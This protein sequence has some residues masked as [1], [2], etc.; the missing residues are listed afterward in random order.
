MKLFQKQLPLKVKHFFLSV[1]LKW[2]IL[3]WFQN[4]SKFWKKY[5]FVRNIHNRI[6]KKYVQLQR[7]FLIFY[8]F[9]YI[10]FFLRLIENFR[11]IFYQIKIY[12]FI[13][14]IYFKDISK[15]Y[16]P[17]ISG[18]YFLKILKKNVFQSIYFLILEFVEYFIK[19][20]RNILE[21]N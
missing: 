15:N 2:L 13:I 19:M 5:I 3:K 20:C 11:N 7:I 4:H 16:R 8:T 6:K 12:I 10:Y 21:K 18:S 14:K 1:L 9:L 17:R